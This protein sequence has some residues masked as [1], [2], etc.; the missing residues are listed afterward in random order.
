MCFE[1]LFRSS[2]RLAGK[3]LLSLTSNLIS[4]EAKNLNGRNVSAANRDVYCTVALDQEEICRT[5]TQRNQAPFFCE[6][7]S[8][9]I[10][11]KFRYL[12]V[13]VLERDRHLK[14]DRAVGKIAIRKSDLHLY[15]NKDHWFPLR[16]VDDDSEVQGMAHIEVKVLDDPDDHSKENFKSTSNNYSK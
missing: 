10:P 14:Q 11:R 8:F 12:S 15:N 4:G 7:F 6:E 9:G 5:Q 2:Y 3:K 16:P 1:T 13:Y